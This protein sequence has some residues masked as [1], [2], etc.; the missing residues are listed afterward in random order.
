MM[1]S[2]TGTG[3]DGNFFEVDAD[4]NMGVH[5]GDPKVHDGLVT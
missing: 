5:V 3:I 4:D 2:A 1:L